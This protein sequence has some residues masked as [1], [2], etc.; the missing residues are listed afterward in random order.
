LH[1]YE[2]LYDNVRVPA[3]AIVGQEGAGWKTILDTLNNERIFIAAVCVGLGQGALDDAVQY[4]KDRMA[5][6]KP[7]GQFQA[8]Q[9]PLA[10]RLMEIET[11]RLITYKAAW[12]QDQGQD[13]SLPA[14]MAKLHASESAFRTTDTG[15]RVLA[16]SG[17]TMDYHMQRYYRDIRQLIFAPVT[18]EMSKNF[19]AQVGLGLPKSY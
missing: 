18:N 16:G 3:S 2:V 13:C 15:M 19:I 1:S 17:F 14:T 8:I 7:I 10:D 11:A 6:D 12:M 4:A 5:F 9:H